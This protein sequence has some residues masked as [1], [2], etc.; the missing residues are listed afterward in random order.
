MNV[1]AKLSIRQGKTICF[2][3]FLAHFLNIPVSQA[4]QILVSSSE[5]SGKM[6][7]ETISS[8]RNAGD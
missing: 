6:D 5:T 7:D 1:K 3:V 4:R 2:D 8:G